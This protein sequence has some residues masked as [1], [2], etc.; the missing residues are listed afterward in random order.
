MNK[1]LLISMSLSVLI[2]SAYAATAATPKEV[3]TNICK[4][5]Q[6]MDFQ[7][8]KKYADEAAVIKINEN[9]AKKIKMAKHIDMLPESKRAQAKKDYDAQIWRRKSA[10]SALNCQNI[11]IQDTD[12]PDHKVALI[13]NKPTFLKRIKGIWK[14]TQ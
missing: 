9:E 4:A 12:N 11:Y 6:K 10:M 7:E 5:L 8:L 2:T 3:A 14:L 1:K 13:D